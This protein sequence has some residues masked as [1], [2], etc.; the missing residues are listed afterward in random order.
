MEAYNEKLHYNNGV[1]KIEFK[2]ICNVLL[3]R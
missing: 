3:K 1:L 2:V